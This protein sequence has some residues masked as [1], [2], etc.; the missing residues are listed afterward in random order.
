MPKDN[1]ASMPSIFELISQIQRYVFYFTLFLIPWFVVPLPSDPT[2]QIR[3]VAFIFLASIIILLEVIKWIWDGKISITK[4][5]F[6]KIF[7]ILIVSFLISTVFASDSW[8]AFW[9]YDGRMGTGLLTM[10][11]L[12][13][14][15]YLARGFFQKKSHVLSAIKALSA[16]ITVLVV[17][18]LLSVLKIDVFGWIPYIEHFFTIGLPLTFSFNEI[19]LIAG[20]SVLLNLYLIVSYAKNKKIQSVIYPLLALIV[21]LISISL[22]S[23]GQGV[24]IPILFFIVMV[25]TTLILWLRLE[26]ELRAIPALV[27]IFSLLVLAASIGFQY[28]SFT[29]TVLGDSFTTLN[30]IH[31]GADIS[32]VVSSSSIVADFFKGLVG[33]GNDSF[34][35]A[36][37]AFRPAVDATISLGNTTFTS[38]SSELLTILANRGLLGVTIWILLGFA[39]IKVLIKSVSSIGKGEKDSGASL[40]E[41]NALFIFLASIFLPFSFLMY[42]LLVVSI[43][44]I[45]VSDSVEKKNT[46][47]FLLKFWAVNVGTVSKDINKTMEGINWFFTIFFALLT[48]A[49]LI[50]LSVKMMSVAYIVRAEAYSIEESEKYEDYEGDIPYSEREAY[51]VRVAGYY[52]N[53]LKYDKTSPFI[54]RKASLI[55]IEIINLLSEKYEDASEEDKKAILSEV[56]VWKNSAIDFSREAISTSPLTYSNWNTRAT[57]YISLINVGLS[58]YSEDALSTLQTCINLNPLDY[59]SYYRAGQIYMVKEDND[60]ALAAFNKVLNINGQHVP[61]LILAARILEEKKDIP[62]AI[63]YLE[64]AKEVLEL[65]EQDS[66]ETYDG[67]I[68]YLEELGANSEKETETTTPTEKE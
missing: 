3:S 5:P 65:N 34:A 52:N 28:D 58:D 9:G 20:S 50:L 53:A 45:I 66:G 35:L 46:E 29:K 25:L 11:V 12:F 10:L 16:G 38:G 21:A 30:P 41:L 51:L 15:F 6:D 4:S 56:S 43:L 31:L 47:E 64:A 36:Y 8:I 17:V 54:N 14:F 32:W 68:S 59:D 7:L 55:S 60:Q 33:V 39:L 37:N 23:V 1:N 62:T 18:S 57:V 27:F 67:I 2:E 63:A 26:K 19:M 48:T 13:G 61:S 40:L 42:F 22:F 24:I 44:L 49:G